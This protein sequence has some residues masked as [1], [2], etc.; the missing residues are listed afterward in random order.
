MYI[1][2]PLQSAFIPGDSTMNQLLFLCKAFSK[3]LDADKE[4]RV[5][6]CGISKV[7]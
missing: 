2:T 5:I 6:F 3:A 4:V 7:F 1:L